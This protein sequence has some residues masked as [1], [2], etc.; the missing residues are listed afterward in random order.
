MER[1]IFEKGKKRR[2]NKSKTHASTA[3]WPNDDEFRGAAR[4][5]SHKPIKTAFRSY[6][7]AKYAPN[8]SNERFFTERQKRRARQRY[9][10]LAEAVAPTRTL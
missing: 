9:P 5:P 3:K 8:V 6:F 2:S 4:L 7:L 1:S 10:R